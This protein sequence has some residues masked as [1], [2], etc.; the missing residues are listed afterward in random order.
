M[1][2]GGDLGGDIASTNKQGRFLDACGDRR[3]LGQRENRV[4]WR[5][6][7]EPG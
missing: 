5:I 6:T 4:Q 3:K 1:W 2:G 7:P